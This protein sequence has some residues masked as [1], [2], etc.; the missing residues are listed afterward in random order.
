MQL[1]GNNN[2]LQLVYN[3]FHVDHIQ[4]ESDRLYIHGVTNTTQ[5][6]C[7]QIL[8]CCIVGHSNERNF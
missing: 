3:W 2:E 7:L 1:T 8:H 5:I 4:H 6:Y